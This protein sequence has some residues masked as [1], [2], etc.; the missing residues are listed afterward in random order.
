MSM[1]SVSPQEKIINNHELAPCAMQKREDM[2]EDGK[3]VEVVVDSQPTTLRIVSAV[4]CALSLV[5]L[6]G[7]GMYERGVGQ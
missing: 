1:N 4:S 5:V 7:V 6:T 3:E 2:Y